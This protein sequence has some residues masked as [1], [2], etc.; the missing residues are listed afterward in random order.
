MIGAGTGVVR[1]RGVVGGTGL[2]GVL[3]GDDPHGV[4]TVLAQGAGDL[5]D[6]GRRRR[7]RRVQHGLHGLEHR[8][9]LLL[10]EVVARELDLALG[11]FPRDPA[12][13]VA[14]ADR[15]QAQLRVLTVLPEHRVHRAVGVDGRDRG[16]LLTQGQ[17]QQD[18]AQG[19]GDPPG[20]GLQ[21][22]VMQFAA[23]VPGL[24]LDVPPVVAAARATPHGHLRV[25]EREIGGVVVRGAHLVL[26]GITHGEVLELV[27]LEPGGALPR[28]IV[29]AF[30]LDLLGDHGAPC[31]ERAAALVGC[32]GAL[33]S[34]NV[35]QS[36]QA[37]R[38]FNT[39]SRF[40]A[41]G[42]CS[43]ARTAS[44]RDVERAAGRSGTRRGFGSLRSTT[45]ACV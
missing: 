23:H 38:R 16:E 11:P 31:V 32:R 40:S 15:V 2:C 14:R 44:L 42:S 41:A 22:L 30:D 7:P 26:H 18:L 35:L 34:T 1:E 37:R 20:G 36:S 21:G 3:R 25:R 5:R 8:A 9:R 33:L 12:A 28:D 24:V 27:Q 10:G 13:L 19:R 43:P 6:R 17:A 29:L 4:A 39:S 45:G